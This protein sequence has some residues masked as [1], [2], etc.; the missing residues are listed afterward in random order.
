MQSFLLWPSAGRCRHPAANVPSLCA[1]AVARLDHATLARA[2]SIV[3]ALAQ[4]PHGAVGAGG[5]ARDKRDALDRMARGFASET[6]DLPDSEAERLIAGLLGV[7][8]A[9]TGAAERGASLATAR[10]L[11]PRPPG[12]ATQASGPTSTAGARTRCI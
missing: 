12:A 6:A 9:S 7:M 3:A 11:A 5:S 4:Q 2:G 10:R 8:A 1:R